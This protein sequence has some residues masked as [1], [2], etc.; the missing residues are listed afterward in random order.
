MFMVSSI[1]DVLHFVSIHVYT[2]VIYEMA[3]ALHSF[4]IEVYL[5]LA[6]EGLIV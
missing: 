6:Q 5:L 3:E 1:V 2:L 4:G